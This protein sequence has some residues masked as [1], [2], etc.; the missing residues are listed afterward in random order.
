MY[1]NSPFCAQKSKNVLGRGADPSPYPSCNGE[2]DIPSPHPTPSAPRSSRPWRSTW[3]APSVLDLGPRRRHSSSSHTFWIRPWI[4]HS[5]SLGRGMILQHMMK[6]LRRL[7][8]SLPSFGPTELIPMYSTGSQPAGDPPCGRL[9]LVLS[10]RPAVKKAWRWKGCVCKKVGNHRS[11]DLSVARQFLTY[12]R[13]T[14]SA[15]KFSYIRS[16]SSDFGPS[17][18]NLRRFWPFCHS[19]LLTIMNMYSTSELENLK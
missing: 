19:H 9:P 6:R 12:A 15:I 2:G 10:T 11:I 13:A 16:A 1:R 5:D 18:P 14:R 17:E 3:L 7:P 4:R 8:H